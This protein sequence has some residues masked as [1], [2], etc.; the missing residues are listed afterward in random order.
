MEGVIIKRV[1]GS[2]G[3]VVVRLIL[4]SGGT[5]LPNTGPKT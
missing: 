2:M 3:L 1:F 4:V 5:K